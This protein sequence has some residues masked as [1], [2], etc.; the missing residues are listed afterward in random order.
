MIIYLHR[1]NYK[2][3][4]DF[5]S[6]NRARDKGRPVFLEQPQKIFAIK[7]FC[8]YIC[9]KLKIDFDVNIR[10]SGSLDGLTDNPANKRGSTKVEG[11]AM[12][13]KNQILVHGNFNIGKTLSI[14]AHEARH[15]W[16]AT[17]NERWTGQISI[18]E[19]R[20]AAIP[21]NNSLVQPSHLKD[22]DL[23][24]YLKSVRE[25][26]ARLWAFELFSSL[27]ELG[28]FTKSVTKKYLE[29][30]LESLDHIMFHDDFLI[31]DLN[32]DSLKGLK[33]I[34]TNLKTELSALV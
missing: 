27:S 24:D 29:E 25:I 10:L 34:A 6:I 30:S 16:Q 32:L 9:D 26:D 31:E 14:I 11:C 2:G 19:L 18:E 8:D 12:V 28:C 13:Y 22:S 20:K 15:I 33:D 5:D 21:E 3:S 7:E 17:Y 4:V 23:S 1:K